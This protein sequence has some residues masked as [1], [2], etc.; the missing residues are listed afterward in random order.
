MQYISTRGNDG[1]VDFEAAMLNGLA[2]DG[3]LY[4]PVEWPELTTEQ[5]RHLR[6]RPYTDVA[7]AVLKPFVGDCIDG[8]TLGAIIADAY[9]QFDHELVAPLVQTGPNEYLMELW[10]G[11]TL[12]FKDVAMQVLGRLYDHVLGK[13]GQRVTLIGATSGDTGSAAIEATRGREHAD[14]FILHPHNRTSDVQRR[15][16]TT[17]DAPNVHNIALEGTF[18]DCQNLVKAMFNDHAFRESVSMSGVN[19]INWARVMPQVVYYVWAALSLGAPSRSVAF[20]VPTGNFG[21]IYAGYAARQMGLPIT[22]LVIA[23]N[24]N[25]ILTRAMQTG[26]HTLGDVHPTM[27]PSMDIQVSSNFERLLFDLYDRD[28]GAVAALMEQLA[29]TGAFTIDPARV[30]KAQELFAAER[31][32]E[33][34][35]LDVIKRVYDR[36]A[37]YIVDPHTA[38]GVGAARREHPAEPQVPMVVLS[39]AHPAKFPD[40]VEKAIGHRPALPDKL[41]DLYEREERFEV[42]PNDL[43]AVISYIKQQL[44]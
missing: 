4:V 1:P 18:D 35:T 11:P 19:S 16:M 29:Q 6:G 7:F 14:I 23:S 31:V 13:R 26:D 37:H 28:G 39:T 12:A 41:A 42:L 25:D 38:V 27:S 5:L 40:A 34:Q 30:A 9:A 3:G 44:A 17:V 21:D 20:A 15:Q 43:N 36:S 22:K 24:I 32:D 10:H 8:D 33:A 2:R